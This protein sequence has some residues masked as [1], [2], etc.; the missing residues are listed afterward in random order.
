M[1]QRSA[2][3]R[4][5]FRT[6]VSAV[7]IAS[8]AMPTMA[9]AAWAQC[10]DMVTQVQKTFATSDKEL[11]D[12]HFARLQKYTPPDSEK[13]FQLSQSKN[14]ITQAG[15]SGDLFK[16]LIQQLLGMLS[17][18]M[19]GIGGIMGNIQKMMGGQ[20]GTGNGANGIGIPSTQTIAGQGSTSVNC[21]TQHP[22]NPDW[23][24]TFTPG[25]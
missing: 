3:R 14:T 2:P 20:S 8:F 7:L 6:S 4:S 23:T 15:Q 10:Q 21:Q 25:Q 16:T 13:D 9:T 12:S 18:L 22:Q 11:L 5:L 19:K 17:G 24:Q 1:P